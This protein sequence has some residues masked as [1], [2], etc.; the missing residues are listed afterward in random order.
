M[1]QASHNP[2]VASPVRIVAAVLEGRVRLMPFEPKQEAIGFH[3]SMADVAAHDAKAAAAA[4]RQIVTEAHQAMSSS[5][6]AASK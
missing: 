2:L 1:L 5:M 3:R 4:M 6:F